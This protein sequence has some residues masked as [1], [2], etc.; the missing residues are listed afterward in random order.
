MSNPG[1]PAFL[2]LVHSQEDSERFDAPNTKGAQGLFFPSSKASTLV[3]ADW[4]KT[5]LPDLLDILELSKPKAVFDFRVT[6]RFNIDRLSRRQFFA[7]LQRHNC[8][9]IDLF[10]RIGIS[11]VRDAQANPALIAAR[12]AE[13]I[14]A[15][16]PSFHGPFVFLIDDDRFDDGYV[17]AFADTLPWRL[18]AWQVFSPSNRTASPTPASR[19]AATPLE[20]RAIF[21]SHATPQDN[22]FVNWLSSKLTLAGYEVWSDISQLK[23]GDAF[24][25]DIERAI[26]GRA[27]KVL[28]VYSKDAI[29]KSGTRKEVFLAL[30]T[31]ELLDIE[32][33]VIPIRIDDTPFSG[34][35]VELIDLQAIDCR[36]SW[37]NGLATLLPVLEL[38]RVPRERQLNSDR[39]TSLIEKTKS[40][41]LVNIAAEETLISTWLPVIRHPSTVY[42]YECSGL[43]PPDVPDCATALDVP[44]F[45]HFALLAST[46]VQEELLLAMKR[47]G[48]GHVS[49]KLRAAIGWQDFLDAKW[50]DLPRVF[51]SDAR[52]LATLLTN[53]AVS[54][55]LSSRETL[56]GKLANEKTFWF[57]ADGSCPKNEIRFLDHRGVSVRRQLIGYSQ[58][59]R[60]YWHFAVE[61]RNLNIAGSSVVQLAPHV[62]FTSDGKRVLP[63]KA[64]LHSLRRSFCRSWWNN[65][66][67]DLLSAFVHAISG[68][69]DHLRIPV[70]A[71]SPMLIQSRFLNFTSPISPMAISDH[72]QQSSN[73]DEIADEW[74][75]EDSTEELEEESSL[76]ETGE[77]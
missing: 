38:D 75:D 30:K 41:A 59:R 18:G 32:R 71:E 29:Q 34:T 4:E 72:G 57:F 74:D 1:R 25:S 47:A 44:A 3:F 67:R 6:P 31:A 54:R 19:A 65:R 51:P 20:R 27:A 8:Q 39:F 62:T 68:D 70:G 37:L 22:N 50:L 61:I 35:Y 11:N 63:S 55:Y 48:Y 14:S 52:R 69:D 42:F 17:H 12:V 23:A 7:L 64:Q 43:M 2:R 76:P 21:I 5:S 66:W 56:T 36:E 24:W 15:L 73:E 13:I 45:A 16:T 58:K 26:R 40:P 46:A 60:V 49:I 53:Q 9:Y 77:P 28:F 33:F 10:G